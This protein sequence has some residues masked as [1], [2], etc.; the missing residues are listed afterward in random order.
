MRTLVLGGSSFVGGRLVR[1]LLAAD[2]EVSVLNRGR[3]AAPRA[4]VEQLTADR[5][6]AASMRAALAGRDW[7]AVLDVSGYIMATDAENFAALV[8]LVDG[9]TTRYVFVS[10][11]MAYATTGWF[12]WFEDGPYRDEP[13]TTY[14]GFKAYAEQ[15]LL[16]RHRRTGLPVAIARPAAIYGPENNI[17]D[18]EAAMFLRLTRGLPVLLPHRGLVTGSYGH[19]DDLAAALVDLAEAPAA[20]GQVFNVSG[21]GVSAG[22]YVAA[23]AEVVG[24]EP[25]IRLVPDEL[26]PELQ[27]PAFSRLFTAR[28][29]GIVSTEKLRTRLGRPPERDFLTGHRE[30]YEWFCSSGLADGPADLNDPLWGKGFDLAYEAEVAG[31][32]EAATP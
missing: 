14:G 10:S 2:A 9:H 19:V 3:T 11:I 18:M 15:L 13:P 17:Y 23:L 4:E 7:D 31:L 12:P 22:Q 16:D 5:R 27:R 1:R 20:V 8:D 28:H 29:H 21:A 32:I 26:L 30:T 25:D 6:D 24:R